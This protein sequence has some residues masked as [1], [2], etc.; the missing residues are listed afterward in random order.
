MSV[1]EKM[2]DIADRLRGY[3]QK[4]D[5]FSLDG[6][7]DKLSLNDM[8]SVIDYVFSM[9]YAIGVNGTAGL[10]DA[11][12]WDYYQCNGKRTVYNF[13]FYGTNWTDANFKPKYPMKITSAAHMFRNAKSLTDLS[14]I[15]MDF[16]ECTNFDLAFNGMDALTKLGNIST[17]S[18]STLYRT[19]LRDKALVEIGEFVVAKDTVFTQTFQLCSALEQITF[20][21]EIGQDLA[22][23]SSPLN[24]SSIISIIKCLVNYTGTEEELTHTLTLTDAA[25]ANLEAIDSTP[26]DEGIAFNGTWREYIASLGWNI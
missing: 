24:G 25:W 2:T 5:T 18:T 3:A 16:S 12:F 21:G 15:D 23:P 26:A 14:A 13:A 4:T 10:S 11:N 7:T 19:F 22:F 8:P 20:V 17:V 9:G 6:K 1:N